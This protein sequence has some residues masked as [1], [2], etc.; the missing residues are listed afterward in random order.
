MVSQS[1]AVDGCKICKNNGPR[2]GEYQYSMFDRDPRAETFARF[3]GREGSGEGER[4]PA[5]DP[6]SY[7]GR[8][9]PE[10]ERESLRGI[11]RD[12]NMARA[13]KMGMGR[14]QLPKN[15]MDWIC[16]PQVSVTLLPL[17]LTCLSHEFDVTCGG[18]ESKL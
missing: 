16:P 2:G 1:V 7:N 15:K 11:L 6:S 4:P 18:V 9:Y 10:S 8:P 5:L 17:C 12:R 14:R 13:W 3:E